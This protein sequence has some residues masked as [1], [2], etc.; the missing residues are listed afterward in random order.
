MSNFLIKLFLG[1]VFVS[2]VSWG[3]SHLFN[4]AAFKNSQATTAN[5]KILKQEAIKHPPAKAEQGKP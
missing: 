5:M 3:V 4:F 1:W 2:L